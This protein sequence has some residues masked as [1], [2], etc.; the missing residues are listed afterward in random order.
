MRKRDVKE[1]EYK[2]M[3]KLFILHGDFTSDRTGR[4]R[5]TRRG[6]GGESSNISLN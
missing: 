1:E 5:T 3:I 6:E 4:R 2:K